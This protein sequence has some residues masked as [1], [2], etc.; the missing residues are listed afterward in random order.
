MTPKITKLILAILALSVLLT[1]ALVFYH[2]DAGGTIFSSEQMT[3]SEDATDAA[4]D[5]R[6]DA[7][8]V[9]GRFTIEGQEFFFE[10]GM[11]WEEFM[12][13]KYYTSNCIVINPASDGSQI[14]DL[15]YYGIPI[16]HP[17]TNLGFTVYDLIEDGCDYTVA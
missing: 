7:P 12:R 2:E 5:A 10:I 11:T 8:V 6:T 3:E 9:L 15:M 4:T 1:F 13:S 14:D 17:E 16:R